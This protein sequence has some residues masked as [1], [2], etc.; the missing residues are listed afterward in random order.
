MKKTILIC[1]DRHWDD[2]EYIRRV[3]HDHNPDEVI[4]GDG[5]GADVLARQCC[6]E[7]RVTVTVYEAFWAKFGNAAGPI[8]NRHM[9]DMKPDLV[10]AFHDDLSS[11]KGTWDTICEAKR[12]KIPF[13][14]VSHGYQR[15]I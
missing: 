15:S 3:I 7:D 9:L 2:K 4:V 10:I 6:L 12:R 5:S 13:L 8:R 1:G 14:V 11:S